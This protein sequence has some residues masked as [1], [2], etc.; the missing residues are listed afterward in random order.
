MIL[1]KFF[2]PLRKEKKNQKQEI[3]NSK[4]LS[5]ENSKNESKEFS[6]IHKINGTVIA[7]FLF[8]KQPTCREYGKLELKEDISQAFCRHYEEA[9]NPS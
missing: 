5:K 1:I 2:F 8:P 6:L 4:Y 7:F 3:K 9:M